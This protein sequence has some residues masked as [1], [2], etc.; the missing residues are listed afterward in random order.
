MN[1][2]H[3]FSIFTHEH[4]CRI[5]QALPTVNTSVTDEYKQSH[6]LQAPLKYKK[7]Q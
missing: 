4:H 3:L 2:K 6:Q 1:T 5:Q 7:I